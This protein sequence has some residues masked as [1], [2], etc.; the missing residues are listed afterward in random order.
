[1]DVVDD[2]AFDE[3]QQRLL[4]LIQLIVAERVAV[5]V[6]PFPSPL[7]GSKA[8]LADDSQGARR[9]GEK[10][11]QIREVNPFLKRADGCLLVGQCPQT[12]S[13][14]IRQDDFQ[15]DDK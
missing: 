7:N 12:H 1:M 13:A 14:A 5:I 6:K 2:L 9:L 15:A 10:S 3:L 11:E 4:S 8:N